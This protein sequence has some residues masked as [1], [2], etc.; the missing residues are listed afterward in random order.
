VPLEILFVADKEKRR[1]REAIFAHFGIKGGSEFSSGGF[2][3]RRINKYF[4]KSTRDSPPSLKATQD[5]KS[6][7]PL[8]P[9]EALV[10]FGDGCH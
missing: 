8:I 5:K 9:K 4:D 1:N 7:P 10:A 3:S 2:L 6:R